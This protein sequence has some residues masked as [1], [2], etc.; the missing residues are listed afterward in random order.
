MRMLWWVSGKT[1]HDRNRNKNT[2]ESDG[3]EPV[4]EKMVENKLRWFRHVQRR[5]VDSVVRRVIQ[6]ERKPTIKG[7]KI[8][9]KTIRKVINKYLEINDMDRNMT[10]DKT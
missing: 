6:M 1:R 5:L 2:R 10:L 7:M 4:V 8:P 9:I 3:V